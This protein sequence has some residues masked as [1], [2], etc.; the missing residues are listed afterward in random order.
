[1]LAARATSSIA[2]VK[3][4]FAGKT[5]RGSVATKAAVVNT[6]T[7]GAVRNT[8]WMPG[9][10][11][12][13]HLNG[14]LSGD[15]GFDPLN[16]GKDPK[17]LAWYVQAELVHCRF[18]MLGAAGVLIPEALTKAGLMNVPVWF[19]AGAVEYPI[20]NT[21]TL[22]IAQVILMGFAEHRRIYDYK[23]PGQLG[24]QADPRMNSW[25][26]I[27]AAVPTGGINGYPG[28]AFDPFGFSKDSKTL[29][30]MKL[31]EIKNGRLAMMAML[32]FY[33]Q[34]LATGVGPTDNL[35]THLA[36]PFHT[37]AGSNFM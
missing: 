31:R 9:S 19:E 32:G 7:V 16:L 2:S 28:E 36:D 22:V 20:A 30:K 10:K 11:H 24:L 8:S 12:P 5:V 14:A 26:G 18:A 15:F 37:T 17:N 35:L 25:A 29:E 34:A 13:E 3:S 23:Y 27:E 4:A 1:M 21:L 33:V 6:T